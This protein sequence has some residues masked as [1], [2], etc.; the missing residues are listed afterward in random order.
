[1]AK[2]NAQGV[3]S[4][5]TAESAEGNVYLDTEV[6]VPEVEEAEEREDV[7]P[8]PVKEDPRGTGVKPSG[9]VKATSLRK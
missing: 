8:E 5:V 9:S 2:I 1:M 7:K 4:D 3:P 6:V